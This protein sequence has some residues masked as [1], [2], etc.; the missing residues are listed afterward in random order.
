MEFLLMKKYYTREREAK[1]LWWSFPA[2]A[3][4]LVRQGG[5]AGW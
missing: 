3:G 5:E 2:L 4:Q 1:K